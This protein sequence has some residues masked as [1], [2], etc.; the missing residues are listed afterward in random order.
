MAELYSYEMENVAW[1]TGGI[2]KSTDGELIS[3]N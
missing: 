2:H 3:V 1:A